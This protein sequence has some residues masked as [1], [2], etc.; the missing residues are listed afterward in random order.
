MPIKQSSRKVLLAAALLVVAVCGIAVHL[1]WYP[2][3]VATYATLLL[4]VAMLLLMKQAAKWQIF[5]LSSTFP[6]AIPQ[7]GPQWNLRTL[8]QGLLCFLGAFA[9]GGLVGL[10]IKFRIIDD[11]SIPIGWLLISPAL[12]LIAVGMFLMVRGVFSRGA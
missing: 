4:V 7:V 9:W 10:G 5:Q 3:K 8:G 12:G 1:L 6:I 2:S 11:V